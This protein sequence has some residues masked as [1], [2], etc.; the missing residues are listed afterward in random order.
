MKIT[1]T[2]FILLS[3]LS[4]HA[5]AGD[6]LIV[7]SGE[8][9][10]I[11]AEQQSLTLDRF[12][13]EDDAQISFAPGITHWQVFAKE[14]AFGN[15]TVIDGHGYSGH[16]GTNGKTNE[17]S[18]G[19]NGVNLATLAAANGESG[20]SG[21]NI[22]MRLGIVQFKSLKIDVSGGKGGQGGK[23]ASIT[24]KT[25][26]KGLTGGNGGNAG[27]GGNGGNVLIAYWSADKD[28]YIPISNYGTGIQIMIEA[29]KSGIAGAGGEGA[30]G[31]QSHD[32]Q[33]GSKS[34]SFGRIEA[35][36]GNPGMP[37]AQGH[38]G[39]EGAFLV[40]P[41]TN[42]DMAQQVTINTPK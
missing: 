35:E 9:I 19:C 34:Q 41:V 16:D 23:G 4:A 18:S 13:M 26:C 17:V 40:R 8:K 29:G 33:H 14:A 25:G 1:L 27:N 42:A 21:V 7:K 24:G 32:K 36:P 15:N 30:S 3:A 39:K 11:T 28:G 37:G 6:S 20:Q 31:G 5:M 38:T 10:T 22:E 12:V 2:S